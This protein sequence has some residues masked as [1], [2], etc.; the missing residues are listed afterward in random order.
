M[1]CTKNAI[2]GITLTFNLLANPFSFRNNIGMKT[3]PTGLIENDK[4]N[5]TDANIFLSFR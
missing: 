5:S 1:N 4:P 3:K 2:N